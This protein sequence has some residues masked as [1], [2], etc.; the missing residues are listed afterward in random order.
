MVP[1]GSILVRGGSTAVLRA[2]FLAYVMGFIDF[3]FYGLDSSFQG[4]VEHA[5]DQSKVDARL[6]V[7]YRGREFESNYQMACQARDFILDKK[8]AERNGCTFHVVGEGLI[9]YI[10]ET[11]DENTSEAE[12]ICQ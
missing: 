11:W 1:E 7:K 8:R 10:Y 3:T 2:P 9:P 4:D 12:I 5:Y 6:K